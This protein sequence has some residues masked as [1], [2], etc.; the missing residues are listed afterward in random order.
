M[1]ALDTQ[2]DD[3][4]DVYVPPTA[5]QSVPPLVRFAVWL[6]ALGIV[7][8]VVGSFVVVLVAIALGNLG[9]LIPDGAL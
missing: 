7:I 6:W 2:Y 5:W 9:A 4:E 8:S 1:T 3:E